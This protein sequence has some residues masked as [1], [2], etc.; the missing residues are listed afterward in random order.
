MLVLL[1]PSGDDFAWCTLH[2]GGWQ[3]GEW[4][5]KFS[6]SHGLLCSGEGLCPSGGRGA[7]A[8]CPKGRTRAS[9]ARSHPAVFFLPYTRSPPANPIV[10]CVLATWGFCL[11]REHAKCISLQGHSRCYSFC[12]PLSSSRSSFGWFRFHFKS[13]LPQEAFPSLRK[14]SVK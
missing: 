2:T 14:L 13:H 5:L 7:F 1:R 12:F 3:R 8:N 9:T 11:S 4:Q 6:H 10:H